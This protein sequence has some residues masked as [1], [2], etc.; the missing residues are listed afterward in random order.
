[1]SPQVY[2]LAPV[3]LYFDPPPNL[4]TAVVPNQ[5][6]DTQLSSFYCS[7]ARGVRLDFA[8][9]ANTDLGGFFSH[10][11]GNLSKAYAVLSFSS[12]QFSLCKRQICD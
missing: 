10:S 7:R 8:A 5:I 1:M 9:L 3:F 6:T 4:I 12:E 2:Q 11:D